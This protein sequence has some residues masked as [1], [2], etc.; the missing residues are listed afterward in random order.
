MQRIVLDRTDLRVS[1]LG[2]GTA[3]L[4]R[5]LSRSTRLR[6][7]DAAFDHGISHFDTAPYYGYGLAEAD[8]GVFLRGRR[9]R[10]TVA[11][12]VGLYP[13]VESSRSA[14]EVLFRKGAGKLL[15]RL[16]SPRIDW[17]LEAAERSLTKS[18]RR[19]GTDYVDVVFL[20]E[21]EFSA[22]DS[23]SWLAW[24]E[25]QRSRGRVRYWGL[26]GKPE[27]V[28]PWL[29]ERHPLAAVLQVQDSLD[30]AE[31][32]IVLRHGRR[33]QLT[34]GYLRRALATGSHMSPA[35]VLRQALRR[36]RDGAILVST[37]SVD[38]LRELIEAVSCPC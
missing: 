22:I 25:E 24:L 20:H 38:H 8:L 7:L 36:N 35:S 26:A 37:R 3:S 23:N 16:S 27:G 13:P 32:D 28:E 18:L 15:P 14:W 17:S 33:L 1:R 5:R 4:H 29:R 6:L 10:V 19:L 30:R 2:F 21:P 31:A 34:Y 12:K 11:T 9:D